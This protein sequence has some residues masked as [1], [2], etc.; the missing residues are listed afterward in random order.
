MRIRSPTKDNARVS[1]SVIEEAA[2][3]PSSIPPFV[4]D[5]AEALSDLNVSGAFS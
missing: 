3:A 5:A 4:E 1:E 2:S